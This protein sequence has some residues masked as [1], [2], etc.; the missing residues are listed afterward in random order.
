VKTGY[1]TE[2]DSGH[3]VGLTDFGL[4]AGGGLAHQ[5]E[6]LAARLIVLVH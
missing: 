3:A 1:E 2:I 6:D 4:V 5:M